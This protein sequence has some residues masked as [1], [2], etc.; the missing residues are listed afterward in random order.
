MIK[1]GM[2]VSSSIF[3]ELLSTVE[4]IGIE[5]TIKSLQDA[6]STSLVL[7][8]LNIDFILNVVTQITSVSKERILSGNDRNDERKMALGLCIYFIKKEF[9]YSYSDLKKIFNKDESVLS[10]YNSLV[11]DI[12]KNPKIGLHKKLDD[13]YKKINLLITEKKLKNG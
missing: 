10:R 3:D 6:K 7:D 1:K 12:P 9:F 5:R 4:V 8:D 11:E 13:Y 2:S